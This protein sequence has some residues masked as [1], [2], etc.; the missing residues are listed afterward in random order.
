[1][2]GPE[3]ESFK[4]IHK[5]WN[6]I[7]LIYMNVL[8]SPSTPKCTYIINK[9]LSKLL[10]HL[11]LQNRFHI[12]YKICYIRHFIFSIPISMVLAQ[13]IGVR[14]VNWQRCQLPLKMHF[15]SLI[16]SQFLPPLFFLLHCDHFL[17]K[18]CSD[19]K[20]Y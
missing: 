13:V 10:P 20:M 15:F 9:L 5:K 1:M 14:A 11:K 17:Q 19:Q 3:G 8:M 2:N 12:K 18:E 7:L 6:T 4:K 16:F